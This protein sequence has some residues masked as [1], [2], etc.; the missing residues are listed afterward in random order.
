MPGHA[1][2]PRGPTRVPGADGQVR[3]LGD[4]PVRVALA[5]AEHADRALGGVACARSA[6]VTT[7]AAAAVGHQAAVELVQRLADHPRGE[8]VVDAERVARPR[9]RV[10]LRPAPRRH[11]DLGQL[12]GGRAVLVH[13]PRRDQ[14][15]VADRRAGGR[16]APRTG[17]RGCSRRRAASIVRLRAAALARRVGDQRDLAAAR[18]RPPAS[19]GARAPRRS[20]RRCRRSRRSAA[21]CRGTRRP[22]P[23]LPPRPCSSRTARRRRG[24]VMPASA[25]ASRAASATIDS[26]VWSGTL[27]SGVSATPAMRHAFDLLGISESRPDRLATPARSGGHRSVARRKCQVTAK[28]MSVLI[29]PIRPLVALICGAS[30]T[31][32]RRVSTSVNFS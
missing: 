19:R 25:S 14:R 30:R 28:R 3:H 27:P 20:R 16:T 7:T 8:H 26:S 22:G 15:V 9:L 11:G 18:R 12:L 32:I 21:G 31:L 29:K 1:R 23:R 6:V 10:E 5:G 13:V 17:R 2:R 24:G 4:V